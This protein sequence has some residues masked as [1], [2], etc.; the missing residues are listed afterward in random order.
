MLNKP[1][2]LVTNVRTIL[3]FLRGFPPLTGRAGWGNRW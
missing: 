1:L 3:T 2:L